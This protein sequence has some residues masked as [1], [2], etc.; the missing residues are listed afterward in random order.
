MRAVPLATIRITR[1]PTRSD[2]VLAMRAGSTP[3]A[4]AASATVAELAF[5]SI[6]TMSGAFSA[7]KA[8]TVSRLMEDHL[9]TIGA[10]SPGNFRRQPGCLLQADSPTGKT[11][12]SGLP[13]EQIAVTCRAAS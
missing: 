1:S 3:N 6:T 13:Y 8:R 5:D 4:A 11:Q 7:K 2:S 9:S 12:V 10:T